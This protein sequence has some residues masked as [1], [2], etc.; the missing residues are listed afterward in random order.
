MATCTTVRVMAGSEEKVVMTEVLSGGKGEVDPPSKT[1]I[2]QVLN[3]VMQQKPKKRG[4]PPKDPNGPP[5]KKRVG[6]A[7]P[8]KTE[9][10]KTRKRNLTRK[11]VHDLL[12]KHGLDNPESVCACLK[13]GIRKGFIPLTPPGVGDGLDVVIAT[14][15]C[16][17]CGEH[18]IKATI[19]DVLY[20]G[21]VGYDYEDGAP[22]SKIRC[23]E[24]DCCG[25][26]VASMCSGKPNLDTGKFYNH[27]TLCSAFGRCLGD[28]REA[29]C[30]ACNRHYFA[31]G[32]GICTNC[33]PT[34]II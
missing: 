32:S 11:Q 30:P 8:G 6:G 3:D 2:K 25:Y 31:G 15:K 28:Y 33:N 10:T 19:R 12:Q 20:Q 4:R 34:C 18:E 1:I 9:G 16:L 23:P 26:Y 24:E 13:E 7:S 14:G 17:V 5:I 21:D 22:D 27:C 29:H